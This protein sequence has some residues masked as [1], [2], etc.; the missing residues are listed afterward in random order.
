[1]AHLKKKRRSYRPNEYPDPNGPPL[2]AS[3]IA[4]SAP[5]SHGAGG[6]FF[7]AANGG[8]GAVSA[9]ICAAA[10]LDP[11]RKHGTHAAGGRFSSGE[12][13]GLRAC[14]GLGPV[15]DAL[16]RG[17]TRRYCRLS[18]PAAALSRQAGGGC[19]GGQAAH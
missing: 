19:S 8:G 9:D 18:P 7:P 1:M 16:S 6:L 12:Q 2:D 4:A 17:G 15:A 10:L 14:G 13:A 5:S 3:A 11:L